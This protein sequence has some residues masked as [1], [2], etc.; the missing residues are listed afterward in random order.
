MKLFYVVVKEIQEIG[1]LLFKN[2]QFL[3]GFQ[4]LKK[5]NQIQLCYLK[6]QLVGKNQNVKTSFKGRI[7]FGVN[8]IIDGSEF[9][10]SKATSQDILRVV[11]YHLRPT[12]NQNHS[13]H[14]TSPPSS[15]DNNNSHEDVEGEED[16]GG[17]CSCCEVGS[18]EIPLRRLQLGVESDQFYP[19][20]SN[21]S[22]KS[23][24]S[25]SRSSIH[26]SIL[27]KN[28]GVYLPFQRSQFID[29]DVDD[30]GRAHTDPGNRLIDDDILQ[31]DE[32]HQNNYDE[33]KG[34]KLKHED[35]EEETKTLFVR[36]GGLDADIPPHL[37]HQ[38]GEEF[39][40]S[41]LINVFVS[42]SI[43]SPPPS[44]S[45]P[46]VEQEEKENNEKNNQN[47][48]KKIYHLSQEVYPS[49]Y[50]LPPDFDQFCFPQHFL[51]SGESSSTI[52]TS[53]TSTSKS[54]TQTHFFVIHE[55]HTKLYG[56]SS[57]IKYDSSNNNKKEEDE[58]EDGF[59]RSNQVSSRSFAVLTK[60]ACFLMP[61]QS[62]LETL[63]SHLQCVQSEFFSPL[64][65]DDEDGDNDKSQQHEGLLHQDMFFEHLYHP[66]LESYLVPLLYSAPVPIHHLFSL[67]LPN[68]LNVLPPL[69]PINFSS[70]KW[71]SFLECTNHLVSIL[72]P[73]T[74][75]TAFICL[76]FER[77]VILHV[78]SEN[79]NQLVP[80]SEGFIKLL[81]PFQYEHAYIP[82]LPS[83]FLDMVHAPFPFFVGVDSNTLP[84][85][86]HEMNQ[87]FAPIFPTMTPILEVDELNE[88]NEEDLESTRQSSLVIPEK[89][90]VLIVDLNAGEIDTSFLSPSFIHF[91]DTILDLIPFQFVSNILTIIHI[92]NNNKKKEKSSSETLDVHM[93]IFIESLFIQ[94]FS[95]LLFQLPDSIY[96]LPK[97]KFG[98]DTNED[99]NSF[100]SKNSLFHLIHLLPHF[101]PTIY[102]VF[103]NSKENQEGDQK[104][105][106]EED[107]NYLKISWENEISGSFLFQEALISTQ[108]F[109]SFLQ[110]LN[111][112]WL[113]PFRQ[114]LF[115]QHS[116]AESQSLNHHHQRSIKQQHQMKILRNLQGNI[117]IESWEDVQFIFEEPKKSLDF[118]EEIILLNQYMFSILLRSYK[119]GEKV[120]CLDYASFSNLPEARPSSSSSVSS[121]L[122]IDIPTSTGF[123]REIDRR[124]TFSDLKDLDLVDGLQILEEEDG[125]DIVNEKKGVDGLAS[126]K[127]PMKE[128]GDHFETSPKIKKEKKMDD[129]TNNKQSGERDS[130]IKEFAKQLHTTPRSSEIPTSRNHQTTTSTI[131]TS[132]SSSTYSP[133][134]KKSISLMTSS[135][136]N[137]SLDLYLQNSNSI[138]SRPS[139]EDEENEEEDGEHSNQSISSIDN[140]P[141]QALLPYS[142]SIVED[143]LV[144]ID[145]IITLIEVYHPINLSGLSDQLDIHLSS[146]CYKI[147][148]MKDI[149]QSYY[150]QFDIGY[151]TPRA[152]QNTTNNNEEQEQH[153]LLNVMKNKVGEDLLSPSPI[154]LRRELSGL[155]QNVDKDP[156]APNFLAS[157]LNF[158]YQTLYLD[159]LVQ[160]IVGE[161][162]GEEILETNNL[163]EGDL[164]EVLVRDQYSHRLQFLFSVLLS[165]SGSDL[166]TDIISKGCKKLMDRKFIR[167]E[168]LC[169]LSNQL[170]EKNE[171][172]EEKEEE[173]EIGKN[174]DC[175]TSFLFQ[176]LSQFRAIHPSGFDGLSAMCLSYLNVVNEI[177]EFDS[178]FLLVY[179]SM[180]FV[181]FHSY[182]SNDENAQSKSLNHLEV[183]YLTHQL[184]FHPISYR[185]EF[186]MASYDLF[187]TSS[188]SP[189]SK[190]EETV[191]FLSVSP[192]FKTLTENRKK[193]L[194]NKTNKQQE[195]FINRRKSANDDGKNQSI[196]NLTCFCEDLCLFG[197]NFERSASILMNI[198]RE[199][200]ISTIQI[201]S[202]CKDIYTSL[203]S[204]STEQQEEEEDQ[205]VE[206]EE[207]KEENEDEKKN[208]E[209]DNN[210]DDSEI[211]ST[212]TRV[213]T[214]SQDVVQKRIFD[215]QSSSSTSTKTNFGHDLVYE[216]EDKEGREQKI[217]TLLPSHMFEDEEKEIEEDRNEKA[218]FGNSVQ[219]EKFVLDS[220]QETI[221]LFHPPIYSTGINECLILGGGDG[222]VK[223][224]SLDSA[225]EEGDKFDRIIW[226]GKKHSQAVSSIQQVTDRSFITTSLDGGM[227]LYHLGD[228]LSWLKLFSQDGIINEEEEVEER[229]MKRRVSSKWKRMKGPEISELKEP[230]NDSIVYFNKN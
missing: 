25:S 62:L 211:D 161:E 229:T 79:L 4:K 192:S 30:H 82:Y 14:L 221:S 9:E 204:Q 60:Y 163:K 124:D 141:E 227:K 132:S 50:H 46:L 1:S 225:H 136:S 144:K 80:V 81:Y 61:L 119:G 205:D 185:E 28:Q 168:F 198:G 203:D 19:F 159:K 216:E 166:T 95:N 196:Q 180:L 199:K 164:D 158:A 228:D 160:W 86:L 189:L 52:D 34:S 154:T 45:K 120:I 151:S 40:P 213:T 212:S 150:K 106:E 157:H 220:Y 47:E 15:L 194:N 21:N 135:S 214:Y 89:L 43:F 111:H 31:H 134:H 63:L 130:P 114:C 5:R 186:W 27:F 219:T 97:K 112:S 208:E 92:N 67:Q 13:H 16:V 183:E 39:I 179:Y 85:L 201:H 110:I 226:D 127:L 147:F 104:E 174:D 193:F 195:E 230:D 152:L 210:D 32:S 78:S 22:Q 48:M 175:E 105:E 54:S 137:N 177:N 153:Q 197:L 71:W 49:S 101:H 128:K 56:I 103:D 64:M 37:L 162:G 73:K 200:G 190:E 156:T 108:S 207:V 145:R 72:P 59:N 121:G 41:G 138:S 84:S 36:K 122:S 51:T 173:E 148:D 172:C 102:D 8:Q 91:I 202:F 87:L 171:D 55:N 107:N 66:F 23:P 44:S 53:N 133:H 35:V 17:E 129:D 68:P 176:S 94:L 123:R 125:D 169:L 149:L 18:V 38:L 222:V 191:R 96:Y 6:I 155:D 217:I 69:P 24:S 65:I 146:I 74:L 117:E 142:I 98:E 7:Y 187:Y 188:S 100:L 170:V 209:E 184:M 83:S 76:L 115:Y 215:D 178:A 90:D 2:S 33:S 12:L 140:I 118:N 165:T 93:S 20:S 182:Q 181:Q 113:D 143:E 116:S 109:Q 57:C 126:I 75:L 10:I 139:E 26:L 99:E 77:R 3:Q 58:E 131:P 206:K 88:N 224:C 223:I 218:Y 70:P 42:T 11:C 167:D 29:I